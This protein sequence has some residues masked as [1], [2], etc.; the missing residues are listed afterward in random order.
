MGPRAQKRK[1]W[2]PRGQAIGRPE[3]DWY[4]GVWGAEPPS[5]NISG[6]L[7]VGCP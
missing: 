5:K 4:R 2:D 1:E 6:G 7:P 3:A